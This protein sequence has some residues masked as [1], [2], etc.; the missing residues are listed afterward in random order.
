M[1]RLKD[2]AFAKTTFNGARIVKEKFLSNLSKKKAYR[3]SGRIVHA[4]NGIDLELMRDS[5]KLNSSNVVSVVTKSEFARK[6]F[7]LKNLAEM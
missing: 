6:I 2:F 5:G 4:A 3:D 1:Y 7:K